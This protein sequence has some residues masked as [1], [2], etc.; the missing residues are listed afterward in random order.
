MR[1]II[2]DI[3]T[4]IICEEIF[5]IAKILIF[6]NSSFWFKIFDSLFL[7]DFKTLFLKNIFYQRMLSAM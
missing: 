7:K 2:G 6:L 5:A 1:V 3:P 4:T